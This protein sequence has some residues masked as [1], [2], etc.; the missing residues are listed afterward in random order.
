M[1]R[2]RIRSSA[3]NSSSIYC[4]SLSSLRNSNKSHTLPNTA[5]TTVSLQEVR[6]LTDDTD[7]VLTVM[8]AGSISIENTVYVKFP[9][10][11]ALT[12]G[13]KYSI[14]FSFGDGT[15]V[16]PGEVVVDCRF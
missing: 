2:R 10:L 4:E 6:D 1:M 3:L 8:P 9:P 11:T 7:V 16:L 14:R 15:N 12:A 5:P 13:R